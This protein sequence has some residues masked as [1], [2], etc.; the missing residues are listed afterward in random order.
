MPRGL[1]ANSP[2]RWGGI[3]D[4]VLALTVAL[5]DGTVVSTPLVP[6]ASIGP[7][8]KSFFIGSEGTLGVILDVTL[9]IFPIPPYQRLDTFSFPTLK[10]GLVSVAND[11]A[12][13]SA[14]IFG[15]LVRR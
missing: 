9:K 13:R 5:A 3:E 14:A 10:A 11:H 15:S 6:R 8:L 2:Q 1:A 7:D 4:L 12:S